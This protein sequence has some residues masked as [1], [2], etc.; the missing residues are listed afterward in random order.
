MQSYNQA[1]TKSIREVKEYLYSICQGNPQIQEIVFYAL[2]I[3][4]IKSQINNHS[5]RQLY[6]YTSIKAQLDYAKNIRELEQHLIM[7]N[8]L[9]KDN[10]QP[11]LTYRRKLYYYVRD[12]FPR[13][14]TVY[15]IVRHLIDKGDLKTI[16]DSLYQE[17]EQ[18]H[19]LAARIFLIE[20]DYRQ[21]Y[22]HLNYVDLDS[23]LSKYKKVLY[24]YSPIKYHKL[25]SGK[26]A[27]FKLAYN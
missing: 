15:Q 6:I 14:L 2:D 23:E 7:M 20:E 25:Y 16:V 8:L 9:I 13:D 26:S 12:N 5:N 21:A 24:N 18:Y 27:S 17:Q 22:E 4:Q 19:Y 11:L 3:D 1:T 10:Y